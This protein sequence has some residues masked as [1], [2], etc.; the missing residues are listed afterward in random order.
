MNRCDTCKYSEYEFSELKL[1]EECVDCTLGYRQKFESDEDCKKYKSI[2]PIEKE[3]QRMDFPE[4]FDEFAEYY[5]IKDKHQIYTT[6][7]DLIPIF[8]VKQWLEH[9][10]ENKQF[11]QCKECDYWKKSENSLQGRCCLLQMYPTGEWFCGNGKR[12]ENKQ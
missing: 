7:I 3:E 6:G 10:E 1:K 2:I 4:T 8:R 11:V 5:S 9:I 12:K